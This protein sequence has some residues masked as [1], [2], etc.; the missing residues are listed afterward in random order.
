MNVVA[1]NTAAGSAA[2]RQLRMRV[3]QSSVSVLVPTD[4]KSVDDMVCPNLPRFVTNS[5][6][7]QTVNALVRLSIAAGS[8]TTAVQKNYEDNL[9]LAIRD[10][11][12]QTQLDALSWSGGSNPIMVLPRTREIASDGSLSSGAISGIALAALFF[13]IF[14]IGYYLLHRNRGKDDGDAKPEYEEY[15]PEDDAED[16][17]AGRS[18]AD[19]SRMTDAAQGSKEEEGVGAMTLGASQA[20]YGKN[21]A[22]AE[23]GLLLDDGDDD[24]DDDGA[25]SSNAGSSGWSSSAGISSLNTGSVDDSND[26]AAAAGATLAGIGLASAFSR[27]L[28]PRDIVVAPRYVGGDWW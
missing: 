12:L 24:D 7:C 28:Q 15:E 16:L 6:L 8:N 2:R 27:N 3:L 18:V 9:M 21:E 25:A 5:T 4:F 17:G 23:P 11:E 22:L 19:A 10:G 26:I 13:T 20:Y 14:P 1:R